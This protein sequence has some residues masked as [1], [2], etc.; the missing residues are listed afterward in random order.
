MTPLSILLIAKNEEKNLAKTLPPLVDFIKGLPEGSELILTDTGSTD[1]TRKIASSFGARINEFSWC[2]DFS[3]ARNFALSQANNDMVLF[4]DCDEIPVETD[5]KAFMSLMEKY[6]NEVGLILRDNHFLERDGKPGIYTDKV[7]RLFSR[8]LYR[9]NGKIHEQVVAKNGKPYQ[10][11]ELPFR[12]DHSGY[13]G[14]KEKLIAK[15]EHYASLLK[16]ELE[17]DPDNPYLYF[18]LGQCYNTLYEDEKALNYY[19]QALAYPLDPETEYVEM[20]MNAIGHCLLHLDRLEEA[21]NFVNK[22]YEKYFHCSDLFCLA[23]SVRMRRGELVQAMLEY[24]NAITCPVHHREGTDSYIPYFNIAY[25]Y[26]AM[27]SKDLAIENY[28]KCGDYP[29]AL[30]KLKELG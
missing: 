3:A 17:E 9:Y 23:G 24:I 25:M 11:Y 28:R 5:G 30:E 13:T 7:P 4:L 26:E 10:V 8:K 6:P 1:A 15:T 20:L 22:Y 19:E 21:Q 14:T 2:E 18:Q 16:A 27:G 12:A 29:P